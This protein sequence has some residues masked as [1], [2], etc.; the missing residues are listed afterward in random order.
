MPNHIPACDYVLQV[1]SDGVTSGIH[2]FN[3]ALINGITDTA[4]TVPL[5]DTEN[6]NNND[7][8][9]NNNDNNNNSSSGFVSFSKCLFSILFCSY[10]FFFI[11]NVVG[12][13]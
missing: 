12:F 4:K 10:K 11:F 3:V 9:N 13:T 7:N 6:N 5:T 2:K 1:K 8:N